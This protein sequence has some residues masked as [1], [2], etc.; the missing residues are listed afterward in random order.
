[1]ITDSTD[2]TTIQKIN[3][4][5][6]MEGSQDNILTVDIITLQSDMRYTIQVSFNNLDGEF[7]ITIST[8]FSKWKTTQII[9]HMCQGEHILYNYDL[10][11][12][13]LIGLYLIYL[14]IKKCLYSV[15]VYMMISCTI[16]ITNIL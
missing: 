5:M 8:N 9:I 14:A 1:M 2:D 12:V 7:N 4:V 3:D 16:V 10:Y 6:L 13:L 11:I 15:V